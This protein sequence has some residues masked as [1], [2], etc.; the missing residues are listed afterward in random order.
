VRIG[1]RVYGGRMGNG[2][3]GAGDGYAFR[4]R[5]LIQL[6]GRAMYRKCGQ[7]LG[8]DFEATPA[9]LEQP[10]YAALS[11][12]WLWAEEKLCNALADEGKFQSIVL[13]VN[14]GLNGLDD[15]LAWLDKLRQA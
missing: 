6:T 13:R 12:A 8:V 4:G 2:P 1:E 9:M 10:I 5:G 3:E 7:A 15:R 14:G 11:A